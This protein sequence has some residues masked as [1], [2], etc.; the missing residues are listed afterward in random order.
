[1]AIMTK[2]WSVPND[3]SFSPP[4][5]R[6]EF[7]G[8]HLNCPC[9]YRASTGCARRG[10]HIRNTTHRNVL[11]RISNHQ[12]VGTAWFVQPFRSGNRSPSIDAER[13]V[14]CEFRS[15]WYWSN[16][17]GNLLLLSSNNHPR[18]R[19]WRGFQLDMR[20]CSRY[21]ERL[22]FGGWYGYVWTWNKDKELKRSK[23]KN[24]EIK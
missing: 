2:R 10:V 7:S 3:V 4:S 6:R 1:M 8:D 16:L 24:Q 18:F 17:Y 14:S 9:T 13:R 21:D 22:K 19:T 5:S 23:N 20:T 12:N 11:K 15:S